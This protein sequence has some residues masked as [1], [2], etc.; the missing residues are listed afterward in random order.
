MDAEKKKKKSKAYWLV[1][2][3]GGSYGLRICYEGPNRGKAREAVEEFLGSPEGKKTG[4]EIQVLRVA[5][6]ATFTADDL[7]P[8]LGKSF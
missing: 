3:P 6:G 1:V 4:E 5:R 7:E 2:V 8:K